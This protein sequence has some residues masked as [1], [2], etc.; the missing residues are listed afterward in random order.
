MSLLN[1]FAN[2][3]IDMLGS[4]LIDMLPA[5]STLK[6]ALKNGLDKVT[7]LIFDP[8][9]GQSVPLAQHSEFQELVGKII[10]VIVGLV[11]RNIL[12]PLD[13]PFVDGD[14]ELMFEQ[15]LLLEF[16]AVLTQAF[17]DALTAK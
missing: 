12:K 10:P 1:D 17:E 14:N 16:Q 8:K 15:G 4:A 5:D 13:I 11:D 7:D 3:G 2:E 6:Q 9:T